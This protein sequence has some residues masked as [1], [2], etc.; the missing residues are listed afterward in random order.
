M[1]GET[2]VEYGRRGCDVV[3]ATGRAFS[4]DDSW[5]RKYIDEFAASEKEV[6]R[7]APHHRGT[8]RM[9]AS[10]SSIRCRSNAAHASR[11]CLFSGVVV[12]FAKAPVAGNTRTFRKGFLQAQCPQHVNEAAAPLPPGIQV[13]AN[14]SLASS[15]DVVE[16]TPSLFMSHDLIFNLGHTISDFFIVFVTM[17]VFDLPFD[18]F[19]LVN[20]DAI[21]G[22][23]PAGRN[24]KLNYA[25][26]P[27]HFSPFFEQCKER[28]SH[29]Q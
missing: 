20:M 6:C 21:R 19:Q 8:S 17:R 23:G 11:A 27:D 5:G 2:R 14:G 25:G 28:A 9:H 7:R 4:C 26:H 12:D 1:N 22:N 16:E 15:C 3:L 10:G 13:Y 18:D 24:N 29:L